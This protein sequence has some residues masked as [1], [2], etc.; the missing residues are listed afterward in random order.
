MIKVLQ[1]VGS[2]ASDPS[3]VGF[4][5][6]KLDVSRLDL[7]PGMTLLQLR[8]LIA[9][10]RPDVV[11]ALAMKARVAAWLA[12][13]K[14]IVHSPVPLAYLG[15]FP[16][17]LAHDGLVVGSCGRITRARNVDAWVLLAQRLTDSRN[18]VKCA[19]IGGGEDEAATLTHLAN[20]NL[21]AKV[22]VSGW[23]PVDQAREKLRGL[24][25]FVQFSREGAGTAS[26]LEAMARGLPVVASN[27]PAHRELVIDGVTGFLVGDEVKLL[28]RC[29]QLLDDAPLRRRLG[30]AGR[31]R[32]R[33]DFSRARML[34]ELSRRYSA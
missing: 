14:K 8:R 22:S 27:I 29:Q 26:I 24:D 23:L 5:P 10:K 21:L 34:A 19:W 30:N 13:V 32:V 7:S 28:E 3:L 9:E 17:P 31:D 15:D 4:D 16:E 20:M 6:A 11:H 12:G 25:L 18:G 33:A 1:V 2:G